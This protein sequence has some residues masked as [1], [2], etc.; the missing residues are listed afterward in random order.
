MADKRRGRKKVLEKLPKGTV[1]TDMAKLQWEIVEP[2]GEG[3]FGVIYSVKKVGSTVKKDIAYAAKVEPHSNGPL[4][5]ERNFF[6]RNLKPEMLAEYKRKMKLSFLGLPEYLGGGSYTVN[7]VSHR[8]LIMERY[9]DGIDKKLKTA[10]DVNFKLLGT[11]CSQI[12]DSLMYIHDKGYAHMDLKPENLLLKFNGKDD[13]VYLIDFGIIDTCTTNPDFKPDKK[14]QHNGT[15]L[16]TSRDS[17]SGVVTKRGDLEILGYNI[18]QWCGVMLPWAKDLKTP[19]V[20]HKK[21]N[22]LVTNIRKELTGQVPEN[23]IK[24]F[25]YVENLKHNQT[26]DYGYAKSL[27]QNL[28]NKAVGKPTPTKRKLNNAVSPSPPKRSTLSDGDNIEK[29]KNS[30]KQKSNVAAI[31][32]RKQKSTGSS[33]DSLVKKTAFSKSTNEKPE[34]AVNG[35]GAKNNVGRGRPRKAV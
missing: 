26:P 22:E 21:K 10:S 20:V 3:G 24:Y 30:R 12:I 29:A 9:G 15:M 11:Y 6:L 33:N 23:V 31:S 1:L 35:T 25:E 17:H 2:I 34:T 28:V 27:L 19:S 14:K 7:N 13:H 16:Y 4:F 32:P 18:L 8:F 5:V